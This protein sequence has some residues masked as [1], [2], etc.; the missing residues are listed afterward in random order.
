[1]LSLQSEGHFIKG[2][3]AD[4]RL[5]PL[6]NFSSPLGIITPKT[7]STKIMSGE[8]ILL[9]PKCLLL[10]HKFAK[11]DRIERNSEKLL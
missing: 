3:V 8:G 4:I 10:V 5:G 9:F 7:A 2:I 6:Q 1:M 11:Y